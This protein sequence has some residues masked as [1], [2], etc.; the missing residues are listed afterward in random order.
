MGAAVPPA[1]RRPP[2]HAGLA[3]RSY[4]RRKA[5]YPIALWEDRCT[6]AFLDRIG[7]HGGI[8]MQM[9]L[10]R[11]VAQ[12]FS[13]RDFLWSLPQ[14]RNDG[15]V[16][17]KFWRWGGGAFNHDFRLPGRSFGLNEWRQHHNLALLS[18]INF[19]SDQI[20]LLES[21]GL[22]PEEVFDVLTIT[23][24]YQD[25]M[26]SNLRDPDGTGPV[27]CVVPD[28]PAAVALAAEFPGC[29]VEQMPADL[30]PALIE[31]RHGPAPG[32]RT[33]TNAERQR[34]Y[35]ASQ[36]AKKA[37]AMTRGKGER[38][39]PETPHKV[40]TALHRNDLRKWHGLPID[41]EHTR[42]A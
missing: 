13:G 30:I 10:C 25:L 6:R 40:Q 31:R 9:A 29:R 4:Q 22:A 26:R 38:I 7:C 23:I 39:T 41:L 36:R 37:A 24:L 3:I 5:H 14:P 18:V 16:K 33:M 35:Q 21:L 8:K 34:K 19:S 42:N 1:L 12:H 28:L 15:G 11:A 2:L 20:R 27:E 17:D 32:E